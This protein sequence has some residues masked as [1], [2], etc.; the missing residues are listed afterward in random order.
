MYFPARFICICPFSRDRCVSFQSLV[1]V[2]IVESPP[3]LFPNKLYIYICIL[4]LQ[5]L[6]ASL[7][8]LQI[9]DSLIPLFDAEIT[10]DFKIGLRNPFF[11]GYI[12]NPSQGS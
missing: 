12:P 10:E 2:L 6:V 1:H 11:F 7:F 8:E 4:F 9:I 5:R 3:P